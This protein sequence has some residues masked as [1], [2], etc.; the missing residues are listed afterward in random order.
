MKILLKIVNSIFLNIIALGLTLLFF[1]KIPDNND[2]ATVFIIIFLFNIL[3]KAYF[4]DVMFTYVFKYNALMAISITIFFI[5]IWPFIPVFLFENNE[6]FFY[7]ISITMAIVPILISTIAKKQFSDNNQN[8]EYNIETYSDKVVR[9]K[10]NMTY[11]LKSRYGDILYGDYKPPV[12]FEY[13]FRELPC[14]GDLSYAFWVMIFYKLINNHTNIIVA[15]IL[16]WT[17]EEKIS[18]INEDDD[19]SLDFK[20]AFDIK[21]PIER[22]IYISMFS[23]STKGELDQDDF[24]IWYKKN[25]NKVKTWIDEYIENQTS[26][27]IKNG[28]LIIEQPGKKIPFK[29]YVNK[30]YI[31]KSI[32]EEAEHLV[33]LYN[34]FNN[35]TLI[36]EK[37][38]KKVHLLNQYMEY[39][40]LFDLTEEV[41]NTIQSMKINFKIQNN[42]NTIAKNSEHAYKLLKII[43]D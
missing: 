3:A 10:T 9:I 24:E 26:L 35:F 2:I 43:N 12:A 20:K 7:E 41:K 15:L 11:H 42:L 34:F 18:F 6:I 37:E 27:L 1:F 28:S 14:N 22:K 17:D 40:A 25:R 19:F 8:E 38:V 29:R 21:N 16:K 36:H 4:W 31:S 32:Y 5:F 39:A 30:Y 13:N 23:L 33:G